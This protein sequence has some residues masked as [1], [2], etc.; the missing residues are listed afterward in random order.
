M[1]DPWDIV[2]PRIPE[3]DKAVEKAFH[4]FGGARSWVA[5]NSALDAGLRVLDLGYGQGLLTVELASH[6]GTA[7]GLDRLHEPCTAGATRWLAERL[8][9]ADR[10]RLI[11]GDA[12]RM[13]FKTN[14]FDRVVSSLAFQDIFM[15]AGAQGVKRV[16][17]EVYRVTAHSGRV[18][19]ADESFPEQARRGAEHLV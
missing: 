4:R 19:L 14:S 2:E 13:P 15:G 5:A 6:T 18:A 9:L 11:A 17:D 12:R 7:V 1:T 10:I 3:A 16:L 8:G